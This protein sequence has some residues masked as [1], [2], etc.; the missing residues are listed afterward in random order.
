MAGEE[1]K[2]EKSAT[3]EKPQAPAP[4]P[5]P[6]SAPAPAVAPAPAATPAQV[7]PN[8][9]AEKQANCLSCAKPIKKLKRYYRDGKFYC[10]KSCWRTYLDKLKEKKQ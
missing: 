3:D 10:N 1:N 8:P 4:A 9:E 2:T 5:A 7:A 6:A